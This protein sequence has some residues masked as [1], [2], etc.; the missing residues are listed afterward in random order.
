MGPEDEWIL[1][2]L[3]VSISWRWNAHW[4]TIVT[5]IAMLPSAGSSIC[6]SWQLTSYQFDCYKLLV[7]QMVS[8]IKTLGSYGEIKATRMNGIILVN[9]TEFVGH[10]LQSSCVTLVCMVFW[11]LS[12]SLK[13]YLDI[14]RWFLL[15][16][17][18]YLEQE[19]ASTILWCKAFYMGTVQAKLQ[20]HHW[21]VWKRKPVF[22]SN[23]FVALGVRNISSLR[24]S[25]RWNGVERKL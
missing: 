8:W 22:S 13:L 6:L 18:L 20:I 2:W 21:P 14:L 9:T 10:F 12:L 4:W 11:M 19:L 5:T 15:H 16:E 7:P 1:F 17:S 25:V 24:M 3:P 23:I